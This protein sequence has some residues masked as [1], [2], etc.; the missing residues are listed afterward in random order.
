MWADMFKRV[1]KPVIGVAWHGGVPK[2]NSRNRRLTL[3]ELLPFFQKQDAHY[4]SLQYKDASKEIAEFKERHPEIDLVQYPFA[5]LTSDYDDTAALV[6]SLDYVVCMQTA[7]A[8]TAG[9]LGVPVTVLVPVASQWRYGT[10]HDSIPWYKS[11]RIIRQ[12]KTGQWRDEIRRI[13]LTGLRGAATEAA[14]DDGLRDGERHV[15]ANGV[16]HH[17]EDGGHASP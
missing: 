13:D 10:A 4:V 1:G 17:R 12:R 2:T 14:P 9:A 8:H 16:L 3:E 6:A 15:R 7:V 11:L 5:T